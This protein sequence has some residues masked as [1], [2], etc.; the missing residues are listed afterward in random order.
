MEMM[1]KRMILLC[2]LAVLLS[3]LSAEPQFRVLYIDSYHQGYEWTDRITEGI[4]E[5]LN[6][7]PSVEL[8]IEHLD[9]KRFS[10]QLVTERFLSL[11]ERKY[12]AA[13]PDAIM[14]SDDSAF[15][16]LRSYRAVL[17]SEIPV[18]FMGINDFDAA[19]AAG[20]DHLYGI[21]QE[22]GLKHSLLFAVSQHPE[23]REIILIHD[24]SATGLSDR[25]HIEQFISEQ[26]LQQTHT[27]TY[28]TD[29]TIDELAEQMSMIPEDAIIIPMHFV[30]DAAGTYIDT[31]A[32][33][34]AVERSE[35]PIYLINDLGLGTTSA[36]G[37]Y[38]RS[39]KEDGRRLARLLLEVLTGSPSPALI[40]RSSSYIF[41]YPALETHGISISDLPAGSTVINGREGL[42]P[43]VIWAL[44]A[45]MILSAGSVLLTLLVYRSKQIEKEHT[46]ML[47]QSL[48]MFPHPVV[49]EQYGP[50]NHIFFVNTAAGEILHADPRDIVSGGRKA[51]HDAVRSAFG[52]LGFDS[53]DAQVMAAG[54]PID[55]P[56]RVFIDP[57]DQRERHY[58][59]HKAPFLWKGHDAIMTSV[60]E[61]TEQ[62]E[63]QKRLRQAEKMQVVGQLTGGI[64]HDF[65]NQIMAIL[66]YAQLLEA[67]TQQEPH[68][69]YI[70]SIIHAAESSRALTAKLLAFSRKDS[71]DR[72]AIDIT[73]AV[74]DMKDLLM[75]TVDKRITLI[76][77]IRDEQLMI[78]GERVLI[79]NS[80]INLGLNGA[81][82]IGEQGSVTFTVRREQL[83]EQT[84][85]E[86]GRTLP[87]GEYVSIAVTD[88]GSGMD[89][90][91]LKQI[92]E[93]FY[94]T[95][96]AG[97][98]TGM[99]LAA[100][101]RTVISHHGSIIVDTTPGVGTTFTL[102]FPRY[103]AVPEEQKPQRLSDSDVQGLPGDAHRRRLLIVD[104]ERLLRYLMRNMLEAA[105]YVVDTAEN[106]AVAVERYRSAVQPYDLVLLDM[107]M[108]M[109]NGFDT[110]KELQGID[111]DVKVIMVSGYADMQQVSMLKDLGMKE[112]VA[113]PVSNE[114]LIRTVHE[115]L[116]C[117]YGG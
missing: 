109:K 20:I 103:T 76:V 14:T 39:G 116:S 65:N 94:T 104:D 51:L 105:G 73:A 15:E 12:A 79:E 63:V 117:T 80:L 47:Q 33:F 82:A 48:D 95:K 2:L 78:Y 27:I 13:P 113:K 30:I 81:D 77:D 85:T 61:I 62:H 114:L 9:A 91:I 44:S 84:V 64:A 101:R 96:Q 24:R 108:P 10:S 43:S 71:T 8:F 60:I 17:G 59:L 40:Y 90:H 97:M 57:S 18:V 87:S 26:G 110:F 67:E 7:E 31:A 115:V 83:E 23:V 72:S 89:P 58:L 111:P 74:Y 68:K 45:L 55:F 86:D 66:G 98:G 35:A 50:S 42:D 93:P 69:R 29:L 5:V 52:D 6:E 53:L 11:L 100:V 4:T 3:G 28:L 16:L 34:S 21:V 49:A 88:T 54:T 37:G 19:M 22:D 70:S 46:A 112:F 32:Y 106:G 38:V 107:I 92:F 1:K 56:E 99:G 36:V 41:H 25:S 102:L 75:R